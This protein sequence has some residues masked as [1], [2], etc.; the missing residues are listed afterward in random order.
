[1]T[2]TPNNAEA[3]HESQASQASQASQRNLKHDFDFTR[4]A[5]FTLCPRKYHYRFNLDR[6]LRTPQ[7]APEFGSAIHSALDEWYKSHD[8]EKAVS[9][10]KAAFTEQPDV[11]DKRTHEMGEWILRNYHE[12]YQSQP[13]TIL[14]T[15]Q[16]FTI[17]LA[18]DTNFIGRIDKIIEWDKTVW[19]VDH[20]TTS[21]LG[22]QYT[23]MAEPNAQFTGYVWAARKLGYNARGIIV[24]ALLTA[25]G[26]LQSG[27][28]AKLTPLLRYDSYR[29]EEII[30]EWEKEFMNT[31]SHLRDCELFNIWP[32]TG[33]FSGACTYYGECPYRRVCMENDSLRER[34]LELD[35]NIEHW[36]PRD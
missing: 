26:L 13:W 34:I 12:R 20:K 25:K 35:Y 3:S 6:V 18:H 23:K 9:I 17:P 7:T 8:V 27:S 22:A 31:L 36:D 14:A 28:R 29:S 33:Q 2:S 15:E 5:T 19:V 11:D 10:F 1:M 4:L 32:M 16:S 21:Q 30:A 24:D